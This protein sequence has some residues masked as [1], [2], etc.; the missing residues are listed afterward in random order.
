MKDPKF[1]TPAELRA[2]A[3]KKEK[4]SKPVKEGF[5]KH[6]LYNFVSW[7]TRFDLVDAVNKGLYFREEQEIDE[8]L[9]NLRCFKKRI[10][11]KGTKF[12]CLVRDGR[13]SWFDDIRYGVEDMNSEWA[14]HHLENI[15]EIE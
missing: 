1:M 4:E 6:D 13:E 9:D 15:R 12:V 11:M 14:N 8:V 7:G 3:D 2:L 10:M 5:L